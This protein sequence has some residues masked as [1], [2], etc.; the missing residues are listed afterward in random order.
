MLRARRN[1]PRAVVKPV[2]YNVVD[3]IAVAHSDMPTAGPWVWG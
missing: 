2:V 1:H 3:V